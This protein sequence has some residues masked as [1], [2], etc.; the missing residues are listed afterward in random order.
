MEKENQRS[1][2]YKIEWMDNGLTGLRLS[3]NDCEQ[4]IRGDINLRIEDAQPLRKSLLKGLCNKFRL[5]TGILVDCNDVLFHSVRL[6][7]CAEISKEI[8]F[9]D[10]PAEAK[11]KIAEGIRIASG[12]WTFV[13]KNLNNV[14]S[15]FASYV[16][17]FRR[18]FTFEKIPDSINVGL[19]YISKDKLE[20]EWYAFNG[21]KESL[22]KKLDCSAN[23]CAIVDYVECV[24]QWG[25]EFNRSSV[26]NEDSFAATTEV[27][28][29]KEAE[30]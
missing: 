14:V 16:I 26:S 30:A 27:S 19:I 7:P 20:K 5:L 10:F 24:Q 15:D 12:D 23:T 2:C 3:Y 21:D 9:A 6:D 1:D 22:A 28:N 11:I 18:C 13:G 29:G 8:N 4:V 25:K 17:K